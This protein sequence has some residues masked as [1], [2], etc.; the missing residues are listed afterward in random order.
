M[1]YFSHRSQTDNGAGRRRKGVGQSFKRQE[2]PL[3]AQGRHREP[4]TVP[5]PTGPDPEDAHRGPE[6]PATAA[7]DVF[8]SVPQDLRAAG[9]APLV[10][11]RGGCLH[12]GHTAMDSQILKRFRADASINTPPV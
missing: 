11:Y 8:V 10:G 1:F 7:D 12:S 6:E 9:A 5:N 2:V 4:E 3:G